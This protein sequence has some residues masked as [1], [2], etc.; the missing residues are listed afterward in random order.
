[1]YSYTNLPKYKPLP[2]WQK[3]ITSGN[4]DNAAFGLLVVAAVVMFEVFS[5]ALPGFFNTLVANFLP[6]FAEIFPK[7]LKKTT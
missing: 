5:K 1:M 3:L 4:V 2:V 6:A 7:F